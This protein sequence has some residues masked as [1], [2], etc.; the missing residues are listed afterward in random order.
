MK[1]KRTAP[2][3][4]LRAR[5]AIERML[6]QDIEATDTQ[7]ARL[8]AATLHEGHDTSLYRFASTGELDFR[9]VMDELGELRVPFDREGW[10]DA[11]GRYVLMEP[12]G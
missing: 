1:S 11:L 2:D 8:I 5:E 10:V 12:R 7:L 4:T 9:L 3:E 6:A